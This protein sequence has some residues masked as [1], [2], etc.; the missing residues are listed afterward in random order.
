MPREIL[1][2]RIVGLDG[3]TWAASERERD[4]DS[5]GINS[6]GQRAQVLQMA[7]FVG[8]IPEKSVFTGHLIIKSEYCMF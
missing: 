1:E 2:L 6:T 4:L 8:N 7:C 3:L 5:N